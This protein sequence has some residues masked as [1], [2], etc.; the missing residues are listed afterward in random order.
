MTIDIRKVLEPL[1]LL[2]LDKCHSVGATIERMSKC[3]A[4]ARLLGEAVINIRKLIEEKRKLVI[5][6][7]GKPDSLLGKLLNQMVQKKKWFSVI[8]RPDEYDKKKNIHRH[9]A[10]VIGGFSERYEDAV[11][12]KPERAIFINQYNLAKPGQISQGYYPDFLPV[13]PRFAVPMIFAA[14]EEWFDGHKWTHLKLLDYL[15]GF[16]GLSKQISEG[17]VTFQKMIGDPDCTVIGTLSGIMTVAKMGGLIS[18]MINFGWLQAIIT[19]GALAGHGLVEEAGMK[20]WKHKPCFDDSMLGS[21]KLNRIDSCI[22]PEE[23]LDQAEEIISEVINANFDGSRPVSP[24][25][26]NF[27]I[28]KYLS[29]NFPKGTS[30][31]R[32]AYEKNVPIFIPAFV[33]SEPGNDILVNNWRRKKEGGQ[34]IVIDCELDSEKLIEIAAGAKKL[35]IFTIGGGVPRNNAQNVAPLIEIL[36]VRLNLGLP[37]VRYVYGCRICPDLPYLGHLGGCTY[38]ENISWRKADPRGRFSEVLADATMILPLYVAA[39][40][41]EMKL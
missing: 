28:G 29:E 11:Y 17:F 18:A 15:Q 10:V 31:F 37:E 41:E 33:D 7:D 16:D 22:E 14:L 23:N 12:N 8:L 9:T 13:D 32:S 25:E 2:E 36:N 40:K 19:T 6:Y 21:Q 26:I 39:I 35:G 27:F 1:E 20:H 30:I 3:G 24:S 5:I 4:G 34:R 38:S